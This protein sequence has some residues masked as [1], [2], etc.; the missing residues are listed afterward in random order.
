MTTTTVKMAEKGGARPELEDKGATGPDRG[1]RGGRGLG[2][3]GKPI[4]GP[5]HREG[6]VLPTRPR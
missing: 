5:D 6:P 4:T 1:D 2:P 3:T